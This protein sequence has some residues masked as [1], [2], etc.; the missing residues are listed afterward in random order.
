MGCAVLEAS[1]ALEWV[2]GVTVERLR[3]LRGEVVSVLFSM[4]RRLAC[5]D[6]EGAERFV[7]TVNGDEVR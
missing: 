3:M 5:F 1:W 7:P 4:K 2:S 6:C